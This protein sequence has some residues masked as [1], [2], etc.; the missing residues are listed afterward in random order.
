[1][2]QVLTT[3][4]VC[5]IP[6][7][8]DRLIR[9]LQA[10]KPT[11]GQESVKSRYRMAIDARK[12]VR[13]SMSFHPTLAYFDD[14]QFSDAMQEHQKNVRKLISTSLPFLPPLKLRS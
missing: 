9:D 6:E 13:A 4:P 8:I 14:S 10:A 1:M 3:N 7:D 11:G 2:Y 5:F 12:L